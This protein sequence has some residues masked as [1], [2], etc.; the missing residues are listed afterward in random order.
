MLKIALASALL[1]PISSKAEE[2]TGRASVVDGDTIEIHE[3][4]IRIFGI[5]APESS[6]RC[7]DKARVEY[8]CGKVAADALDEFL[9]QSRPLTCNVV[10]YD[11]NQRA[12]AR[13]RRADGADVAG[14]LVKNGL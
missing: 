7:T 2:L 1:L 4:R 6:Q 3:Q 8:R 10:D 11:R 13:C 12:V 9:A 14:W 5:D